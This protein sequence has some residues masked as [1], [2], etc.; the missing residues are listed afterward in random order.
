MLF[1]VLTFLSYAFSSSNA[2]IG[3]PFRCEIVEI[4]LPLALP[5]S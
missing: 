1:Y 2:L 5:R 3:I 4:L